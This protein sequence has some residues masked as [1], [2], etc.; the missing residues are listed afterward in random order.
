MSVLGVIVNYRTAKLAIDAV[1]SLLTDFEGLDAKVTVVENDS[2][3]GSLEILRR[4]HESEG[5][6]ERVRVVASSR[7][8]GFGFGNNVAISEALASP[9]APDYFFL[10]NPDAR[11]RP[12]TT[13]ALLDFFAE[14][15]L[16]GIAG[17]RILGG[18][19]NPAVSCFRF[20]SILGELEAGLHFSLATRLLERSVV[21]MPPPE[22]TCEVDWVSGSSCMIRREALERAGLFDEEFFLYCEEVDLC[23]R[24]REAGFSIHH[25]E[26]TLV[27]HLEGA[28]TGVR[29]SR[30]RPSYW[31]DSRRR[32]FE[33]HHGKA[34]YVSATLVWALAASVYRARCALLGR[35]INAPP[36]ALRDQME[37]L[38]GV[39]RTATSKGSG[40]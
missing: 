28:S 11:V 4:A 19:G 36:H 37:H 35:S 18:D 17:T 38:L 26:G 31:F 16:A 9:S 6:N 12:G 40:G 22:H 14:Q 21:A 24:V 30:R 13:R 29:D 7:N 34:Y 15:P 27:E 32:Y 2:K 25:V 23:R 8:G 5:W 1:R 39:G 3:D 20:P 10:L 33:K